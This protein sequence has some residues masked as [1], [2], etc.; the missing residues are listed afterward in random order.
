MI[1]DATTMK[2]GLT[3]RKTKCLYPIS[4]AFTSGTPSD[5]QNLYD[6]VRFSVSSMDNS[7]TSN[8]IK[9]VCIK[10]L[11]IDVILG[12]LFLESHHVV[13]DTFERT[14]I[15][16]DGYNLLKGVPCDIK[17]PK[18]RTSVKQQ[19]QDTFFSVR[20][21]KMVLH[22]ELKGKIPVFPALKVPMNGILASIFQ[23]TKRLEL[24]EKIEHL[25][26]EFADVFQPPPHVSLLP[27]DVYAKI[28][29]KDVVFTITSTHHP[30]L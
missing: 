11:C 25:K 16:Q 19:R 29:L 2:L 4:P 13:V 5:L 6:W 21:K 23:T 7:W 28:N 15:T 3:R 24:E 17:R 14:A 18:L 1:D 12:L 10:N 26:A 27:N 20:E 9:A 8:T 30:E 22:E